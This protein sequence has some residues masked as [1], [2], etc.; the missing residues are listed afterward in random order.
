MTHARI[1]NLVARLDAYDPNSMPEL[2]READELIRV[3]G[4]DGLTE[5]TRA[6][7]DLVER[8]ENCQS[9]L[10]SVL[11]LL[12]DPELVPLFRRC[13]GQLI[14]AQD[15]GGMYAAMMALDRV[16]EPVFGGLAIRSILDWEKNRQ[17]ALDY[18]ERVS[19][20]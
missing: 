10:V 3:S 1:Q 9:E 14:A 6:I 7:V 15:A 8:A 19:H 17:L 12:A 11:G 13:L 18:L 20:E 2:V 4:F 16:D 5:L